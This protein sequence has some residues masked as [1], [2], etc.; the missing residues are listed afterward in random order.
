MTQNSIL[1]HSRA[2]EGVHGV[3]VAP[4]SPFDLT[5]TIQSEDFHTST[6]RTSTTEANQQ[7]LMQ[8]LWH[9]RPAC[10]RP[11]HCSISCHG[12]QNL[13]ERF[14]NVVT[15]IPFIALGIQ[16]PRKNVNSKLYANSLIG[17]GVASSMYHSS[18]GRLRKFLRWVDYTM[19][20]TTTVCLSMALRNENP[21]LLMAA[22]AIFL[23]VNPMMVSV[24]HTG[25]MEVAFAKRALKDPDLRMAHTVHKMSSLL[26]CMLFVA[27]DL[28]PKTPY[29]HAAW[30][31]AAAVGVG[32]CNK[33]LE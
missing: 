13:A 22:S 5:E 4:H 3:Q 14:A 31:L 32:T 9:Q 30:H 2:L 28:F 25:M 23:P 1:N 19:I 27:D 8:R 11:I 18:R 21:K 15:S 26:G 10:L 6:G 16:A 29:L 17:V 7:L 24:I 33:L 20:A 12:D